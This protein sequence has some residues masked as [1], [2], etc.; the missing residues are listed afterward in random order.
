[1]PI[2]LPARWRSLLTNPKKRKAAIQAFVGTVLV[3]GAVVSA[4]VL[5][6]RQLGALQSMELA[7]YDHLLRRRPDPGLDD[8]FLVVGISEQDIQTLNQFPIHDGTL[9]TALANLE[10]Y[11]PL[12]IGIDI[13]RDVPQGEGREELTE[14]IASSDQIISICVMSAADDPGLPPAPG[15]PDERVAFAD[16][17]QDAGG[18]VRRAILVAVPEA[19]DVPP[20]SNHL[21][22]N[23]NPDNQLISLGFSLALNYLAARN[24][25]PELAEGGEIRLGE[26][27]LHRLTERSG[28]YH[29]PGVGDYQVLLNY[30]SASN[31]VRVVDLTEVLNNEVDPAWIEGKI[32]LIGYVSEIARDIFFTPFS[33][34]TEEPDL[35][36]PGV[37][38]HAQ[39]TSQLISAALGERPLLTYWANW[40]EVL[41]IVGWAVVGGAIAYVG[42][43]WWVFVLGEGAAIL[44]VY[45]ISY[46]LFAQSVWIPLVPPLIALVATAVGVVLVDR[47]NKGGY[48]Q[49]VYEQVRDQVQGILKPTIEIDEEKRARQVS[50]ITETGYF[51][52]LMARAKAIREQR[53][54][55]EQTEEKDE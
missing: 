6:V 47:A 30:R 49:A 12:A 35:A 39:I 52:D 17:P 20:P 45:G 34:S 51:Q 15:T 32:V 29:Y 50:E 46:S 16:L 2:P 5:A 48:T 11:E 7:A 19:P 18:V 28:G 23:P 25:V 9:A 24:I 54:A 10:Q 38:I 8:R 3:T 13:G 1:M 53:A 14:Q 4:V 40:Q 44:V 26:A 55:A 33:G 41:W 42:R 21:C 27:I 31:A 36:M 37:V 43:R 22:N